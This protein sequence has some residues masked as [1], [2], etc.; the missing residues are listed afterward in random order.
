MADISRSPFTGATSTH[1]RKKRY[2]SR[3]FYLILLTL[4]SLSAASILLHRAT[5]SYGPI[6]GSLRKRDGGTPS[7]LV[8]GED[9]SSEV[10]TILYFIRNF[11]WYILPSW[12]YILTLRGGLLVVSACP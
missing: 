8:T 7:G 4:L 12:V 3:S 10:L 6:R 5:E 1:N 2:S 11:P 9:E